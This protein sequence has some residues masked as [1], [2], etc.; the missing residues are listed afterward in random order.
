MH[1]AGP[2][3]NKPTRHIQLP[4]A[5]VGHHVSNCDSKIGQHGHGHLGQTRH[6][7]QGVVHTGVVRVLQQWRCLPLSGAA[8]KLLQ[9][10]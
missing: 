7:D 6:A 2:G 3:F 1:L 5:E 4:A 9:W 10:P 8:G